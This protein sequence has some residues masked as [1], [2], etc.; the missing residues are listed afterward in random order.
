[1]WSQQADALT[2]APVAGRNFE[3]AALSAGESADVLL[4]LMELPHPDAEVR[5]AVEAG[6]AWLKAHTIYGQAGVGGGRR[7]EGGPPPVPR[8][9]E[10]A[11]G[12]G[13]IWARYTSLTTDKPVFGDRDKTI[14]DTADELSVER[15][16]GYAW[17]SGEAKRALDAY[18]R[19]RAK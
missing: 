4:F 16:N 19:W 6:V 17:Y 2:L 9:L 11:V 5:A 12:A 15:K 1:M 13:P 7:S 3:P 8:H 10:S 18:A 14:H